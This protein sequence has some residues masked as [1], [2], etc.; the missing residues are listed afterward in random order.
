MKQGGMHP[1]MSLPEPTRKPRPS[2]ERFHSRWWAVACLIPIALAGVMAPETIVRTVKAEK[3]SDE[4]KPRIPRVWDDHAL[5]TLEVPLADPQASPKFV[6]SEWYYKIPVRPIYKSYPVY[7]PDKEPPGYMEW[8]KQQE[9]Q[10]AFDSSKLR[11]KE[12]WIKA[13]ELVYDAPI[14]FNTPLFM[15]KA[16]L[17]N[18]EWYRKLHVPVAKDGT[19]P[20]ARYVIRE[21][22]KI[23]LGEGS[24]NT[25]HTRIL[26]D[27]TVVK[28]A[29]GNFPYDRIV[30]YALRSRLAESKDPKAFTKWIENEWH[31]ALGVPWLHPDPFADAET[32]SIPQ[33][34]SLHEAIP[35]GVAIRV[36]TS[37]RYPPLIPSLFGVKDR[38]YLD[39]TGL[40]QQRSI[41]DLMRY[42]ALV[43]VGVRF[44]TFLNFKVLEKLPDPST[45]FR[46]GDDQLYALALYLYSLKSPPNPNK[47]GALAARGQRVFAREGCATCHTPPLYTN[48]MLTPVDGFTPP[49]ADFRR[50]AILP[51]S[52][53]TD[54]GLALETREGTGYYRVPTLRGVWLRG[55]FQ[56]DGAVATL[57]DWFNPRRLRDD[58]VPTGFRGV[59]ITHRAVK[60]H[61][62]GLDLSKEDRRALIAFL[63]TL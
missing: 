7:R 14:G 40:I 21:K 46:Y 25:C 42:D 9:P 20:F 41:G 35:P 22:G 56:H 19:V 1:P 15:T 59:G 37:L 33:I 34:A 6:S 51:L 43:Q 63:K 30:G 27:G 2:T 39:S 11:T 8:L 48:N 57:E 4:F 3:A 29:Q 26:P 52:V 31:K 62:F 16:D 44:E 55:P 38:R 36:N 28:G 23:D 49:P 50:F 58:Y 61:P 13:G 17:R 12:D 47:F 54:P 18:P 5:A 24:C 60:G 32:M 53:H 45:E 10:V